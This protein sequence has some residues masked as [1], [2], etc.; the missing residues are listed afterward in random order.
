MTR[1]W[2]VSVQTRSRLDASCRVKSGFCDVST[3]S[4]SASSATAL[5]VS[6]TAYKYV[7]CTYLWR[8]W[9]HLIW[10]WTRSETVE[11]QTRPTAA[12]QVVRTL[13][14]LFT[15]QCKLM[16]A[17]GGEWRS[18]AGNVTAGLAETNGS[19]RLD[20]TNVTCGLSALEIEDQHQPLRSLGLWVNPV[21]GQRR[22]I[23]NLLPSRTSGHCA[24]LL[25]TFLVHTKT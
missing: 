17:K 22:L 23:L 13:T 14:P 2:D 4:L 5:N 21:V 11:L 9:I 3:I 12:K 18:E 1:G 25:C 10:T 15:K 24:M 19:L 16:P 7:Q 6:Q 20:M 8:D